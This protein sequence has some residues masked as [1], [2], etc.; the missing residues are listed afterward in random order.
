M[1]SRRNLKKDIRYIF[2]ELVTEIYM[3]QKFNPQADEVKLNEILKEV[4]THY[5]DYIS[6]ISRPD[7]KDNSKLV[8]NHFNKIIEDLQAKTLPLVDKLD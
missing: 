7:G 2:N 8:K 3:Y 1:A 6:R 4:L 5:N